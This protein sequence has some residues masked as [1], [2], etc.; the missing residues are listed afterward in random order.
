METVSKKEIIQK[1][2]ALKNGS[3]LGLRL[4]EVFGAGFVFIELNPSYPQK[5][6]K[7]YLMRWGKGEAETKAQHPFMTTD[8]P[9]HIAGWVSDRAALWLP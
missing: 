7:K 2:E 9:K 6:Q 3:V 8:K 5:G 1:M 4:G